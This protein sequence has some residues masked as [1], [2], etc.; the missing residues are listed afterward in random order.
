MLI[1]IL[2]GARVE[3]TEYALAALDTAMEEYMEAS[4]CF[5]FNAAV[6]SKDPFNESLGSLWAS[7]RGCP[8]RIF[9]RME[10]LL[11]AVDYCIF[12]LEK[13]D[14]ETKR[15]FMKY[16]MMGKHGKVIKV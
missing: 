14:E 12:I 5:L 7:R 1:G 3:K 9:E 11:Y 16:K 10:K 15:A 13:N 4:Q 2:G 6:L 8:I